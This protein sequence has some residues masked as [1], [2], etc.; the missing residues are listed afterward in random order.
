MDVKNL[1]MSP[2]GY[3]RTVTPE[4]KPVQKIAKSEN[5]VIN[6]EKQKNI[7]NSIGP[8]TKNDKTN[9][10]VSEKML[11]EAIE[12]ANKAVLGHNTNLHISIHESTKELLVKVVD[13]DTNEV[14][15]E[16]PSEKILDM[17][18]KMCEMAGIL[19]DERR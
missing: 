11:I 9:L 17:V 6:E 16:I 3:T 10:P 15:R 18:A 5:E 19:V 14:I 2:N 8:I 1:D 7:G 4:A 12:R 13:R